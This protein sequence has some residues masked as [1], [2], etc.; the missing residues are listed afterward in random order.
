MPVIVAAFEGSSKPA[1]TRSPR[2]TFEHLSKRAPKPIPVGPTALPRSGRGRSRANSG[3][4]V[5]DWTRG[6]SN[7]HYYSGSGSR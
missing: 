3:P 2:D 4:K 5:L 7:T 6:V 1:K